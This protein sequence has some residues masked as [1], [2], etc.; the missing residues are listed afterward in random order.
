MLDGRNATA[1]GVHDDGDAI[2][3]FVGDLQSRGFDRFAGCC[4][5]ELREAIHAFGRLGIHEIP[6][7]KVRHFARD[8]HVEIRW[9]PRLNAADA[10]S[11]GEETLPSRLRADPE[12]RN[13]T[14]AGYHDA[15][16]RRIPSPEASRS[17]S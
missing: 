14:H 1:A 13:G 12:W 16:H 3:V 9:I 11:S 5:R 6:G 15:L 4:D 10:R 7:D 17:Q 2:S 8:L